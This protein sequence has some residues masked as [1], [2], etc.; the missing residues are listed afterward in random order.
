MLNG[1]ALPGR[2][3]SGEALAIGVVGG[4]FDLSIEVSLADP[5]SVPRMFNSAVFGL[6]EPRIQRYLHFF[7]RITP[8]GRNEAWLIPDLVDDP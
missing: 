4:S 6:T 3:I 1:G 2:M 5:S 8:E 7:A